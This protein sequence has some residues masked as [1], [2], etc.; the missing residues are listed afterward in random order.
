MSNAIIFDIRGNPSSFRN[1]IAQSVSSLSRFKTGIAG[2]AGTMKNMVSG[3]ISMNTQI[4][5]FRSTMQGVDFVKDSVRQFG[6]FEYGMKQIKAVSGSSEQD[7]RGIE[8]VIQDVGIATQFSVKDIQKGAFN[9]ATLGVKGTENFKKLM[10][11]VANAA[12][13]LDVDFNRAAEVV[14]ATL[15]QYNM[16]MKDA[17]KVADMLT[18]AYTSSS[19]NLEKFAIASQ[20]AGLAA[21]AFG[22]G[23]DDILPLIMSLTDQ[24]I[25]ASIAG[26]Q[27]RTGFLKLIKPTSEA[28]KELKAFGLSIKDVDANKL[29]FIDIL[30]NIEKSGMKMKS[31]VSIFGVR[32][33]P[34]FDALINAKNAD[35]GKKGVEILREYQKAVRE[36]GI[37]AKHAEE[38]QRGLH[39]AFLIF[40]AKME[41]LKTKVGGFIQEFLGLDKIVLSVG[42]SIGSLADFI[43]TIDMKTLETAGIKIFDVKE[44]SKS[45]IAIM[46]AAI[47]L[48]VT[49]AMY[50]ATSF[51]VVMS[52]NLPLIMDTGGQLLILA[53]GKASSILINSMIDMTIIMSGA[54]T[55]ITANIKDSLAGM[56]ENIPGMGG[57]ATAMKSSATTDRL[58]VTAMENAP[59]VQDMKSGVDESFNKGAKNA[60]KGWSEAVK[61]FDAVTD[62]S[63]EM[64]KAVQEMAKKNKWNITGVNEKFYEFT[65]SLSKTFDIGKNTQRN[66]RISVGAMP[67]EDIIAID[68]ATKTSRPPIGKYTSPEEM[69]SFFAGK[70]N[71]SMT[72]I[73]SSGL[74]RNINKLST[75]QEK[76]LA[77]WMGKTVGIAGG[78]LE[79][80][81]KQGSSIIKIDTVVNNQGAT[82]NN[83]NASGKK[84]MFGQASSVNPLGDQ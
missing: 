8:K 3:I 40:D 10:P 46:P 56:V 30:G 83:Y 61:T 82:F 31:M 19:M 47:D 68:N 18:G 60:A 51:L 65:N 9:L 32:A 45:L 52:K 62:I 36:V 64:T 67:L 69:S 1:A 12:V 39:F 6:D 34:I 81:T 63:E 42:E 79:K 37:S 66:K 57:I 14:L 22:K 7:L 33:A 4:I 84:T 16:P 38:R 73:P 13:T 15:K 80:E 54:F 5:G 27:L 74:F 35:T 49:A 70:K 2:I 21:K 59:W 48:F 75:K 55:N 72:K 28:K 11:A 78:Q 76:E 17:V 26:T 24:G 53:M 23:L 25:D 29:S 58:M 50:G 43:S 77:E 41:V 71:Y 20:Y 44:I